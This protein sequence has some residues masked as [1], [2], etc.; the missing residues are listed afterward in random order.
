MKALM[1]A[2]LKAQQAAKTV[3]KDS[4]NSYSKYAY[5]SSDD[6]I[7]EARSALTG[8]GLVFLCTGWKPVTEQ[9]GDGVMLARMVV[10]YALC[11]PE[12]GEEMKTQTSTPIMPE[13][14]RPED[15]A[16]ATAL[17]YNLG[18]TLRGLL[19]IPRG[20]SDADADRRDDRGRDTRSQ[21]AQVDGVLKA[22]AIEAI[23]SAT[24]V[25]ALEALGPKFVKDNLHND[26]DV[27]R[28]FGLKKSAFFDMVAKVVNSAADKENLELAIKNVSP[29]FKS[30]PKFKTL[31]EAREKAL[32]AS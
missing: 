23:A 24:D 10:D 13:K 25:D 6:V 28:A 9:A 20:D 4:Q 19:L 8:A 31:V 26:D 18:Y 17:T 11:H 29:V 2:L 22:R 7:A 32:A 15:K 14:G 21:Q 5:A 16:E 3:A 30:H 27:K 12:S 1:G